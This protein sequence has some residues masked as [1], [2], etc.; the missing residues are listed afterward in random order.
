MREVPGSI[1]GQTLLFPFFLFT[2]LSYSRRS[3]RAH[4]ID[5]VENF[6]AD[7]YLSGAADVAPSDDRSIPGPG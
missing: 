6:E 2:D 7:V 3:A 1:P 5:S 4:M